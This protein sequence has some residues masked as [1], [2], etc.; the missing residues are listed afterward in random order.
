MGGF[1]E[2]ERAGK[3][4]ELVS[5]DRRIAT[6]LPSRTTSCFGAQ[7][8][9]WTELRG[10]PLPRKR[11]QGNRCASPAGKDAADAVMDETM[12]PQRVRSC[13]QGQQDSH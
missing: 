8:S 3:A 10:G 7:L 5:N 4:A 12:V 1:E 13:G 2:G 6:R 9:L 11:T